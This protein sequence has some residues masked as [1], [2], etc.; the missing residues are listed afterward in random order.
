MGGKLRLVAEFLNP[1]PV[2]INIG[3]LGSLGTDGDRATVIACHA[4]WLRDRARSSA[5]T[6]RIARQ[7]SCVPLHPAACHGDLL[8]RL[9]N[10]TRD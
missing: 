1:K 3:S 10:A 2:N 5:R 7:G 9:A 4:A 8:L 6:G